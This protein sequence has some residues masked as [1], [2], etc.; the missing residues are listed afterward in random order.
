[1]FGKY[2]WA[3]GAILNGQYFASLILTAASV[4]ITLLI[5]ELLLGQGSFTQ[6]ESIQF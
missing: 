4:I 5:R 1:M 2:L 3:A 6:L